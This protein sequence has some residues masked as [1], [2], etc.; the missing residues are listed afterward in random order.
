[1]TGK[2]LSQLR[3]E[4]PAPAMTGGT[5]L[6]GLQV[7]QNVAIDGDQ[8]ADF[9]LGGLTATVTTGAPGS[10]GAFVVA[11]E[12]SAR[13]LQLTLPGLTDI[14]SAV[15]A[16][17]GGTSQFFAAAADG[18][19]NGVINTTAL[20]AGAGGTNDQFDVAFTGGAGTGAAAR[21][22]VAGGVLTQIT[23]TNPGVGYTSAPAMSFAASAGL[24]GASATAVFGPRNSVGQFFWVGNA[25]YATLY[26]VTAGPAATSTGLSIANGQITND[27]LRA[28]KAIIGEDTLNNTILKAT[29]ID[30]YGV[31]VP[32]AGSNGVANNS[33]GQVTVITRPGQLRRLWGWMQTGGNFEVKVWRPETNAA[34]TLLTTYKCIA[35]ATITST[36]TGFKE[37][38]EDA[39]LPKVKMIPGD[40]LLVKNTVGKFAVVLSGTQYR[41]AGVD[42][43]I[44]GQ[45]GLAAPAAGAGES[46]QVGFEL[47][48]SAVSVNHSTRLAA[49][50]IKNHRAP[51]EMHGATTQFVE[52]LFTATTLPAGW[53]ANGWTT[54]AA[55]VLS[56]AGGLGAHLSCGQQCVFDEMRSF[57]LFDMLSLTAK[58]GIYFAAIEAGN[59]NGT[60]LEVDPVAQTLVV[61][62]ASTYAGAAITLRGTS[63]VWSAAPILNRR[64]MLDLYKNK[65]SHTY[66]LIDTITQAVICTYNMTMAA[67]GDAAGRARTTGTPGYLQRVG[68]AGETRLVDSGTF[69]MGKPAPSLMIFGT[70]L[71]EASTL[72][73]NYALGWASLVQ[74]QVNARHG[75]GSCI[76]SARG[77]DTSDGIL[78][79]IEWCRDKFRPRDVILENAAN[80]GNAAVWKPNTIKSI[81]ML[82]AMGVQRIIVPKAVPRG[83][84]G[85]A[86]QA[87]K[88]A[89]NVMID[90][91][92]L[93]PDVYTCNWHY[94]LTVGND[95][96]TID[97]SLADPDLTHYGITG[98]SRQATSMMTECPFL[99]M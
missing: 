76:I 58:H 32:G 7:D 48:C 19:S 44:E 9:V 8:V 18:I 54:S 47:E 38:Y 36:G 96:L 24:A 98:N 2:T 85:G 12:G 51:G 3:L 64:Y 78:A 52:Q 75:A 41:V 94:Q 77:G 21:F 22:V 69:V 29:F 86:D 46:V 74:A 82:R 28:L 30:S 72:G 31:A 13:E 55:G 84:T 40:I 90:G 95:G 67:A 27:T 63:G 70:S 25:N 79:R 93:G 17:L 56:P 57:A 99:L 33:Y 66:R 35:A 37:F 4:S 23:I 43:S 91:G 6:A 53:T 62:S 11:G 1:M 16:G 50:E 14:A 92:Q 61:Y 97:T 80:D 34:G 87:A 20:V 83:V 42:N 60:Y 73:S 49:L 45:T 68:A 10:N 15:L 89:I 5:V 81:A 71:S 26:S 59:P 39:G 88:N 65:F